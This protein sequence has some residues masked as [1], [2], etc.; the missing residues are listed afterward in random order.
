[1]WLGEELCEATWE[2]EESIPQEIIREFEQ[3]VASSV[4]DLTVPSGMGQ[5]VHTLTVSAQNK[6]KSKSPEDRQVVKESDGYVNLAVKVCKLL[7]V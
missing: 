3:G 1:M 6:S 2:S 5:T 4:T 7:D